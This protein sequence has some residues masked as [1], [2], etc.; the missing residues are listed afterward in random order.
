MKNTNL[1]STRFKELRESN[2]LTQSQI[3][4][5]LNIDQS[6][7]SKFEKGE[8]NLSVDLLEK[9]CDLFGCNLKYFEDEDEE[10]KPMSIAFR[11]SS[12]Q[13][14][15]LETIAAINKVALNVRFINSML[16]EDNI[17]E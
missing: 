5:F 4:K 6:Y 8:R 3:A 1:I 12:L 13:N 10:Y 2:N 9:V 16:E 14:E 15:D 7:I 17:E 11:S